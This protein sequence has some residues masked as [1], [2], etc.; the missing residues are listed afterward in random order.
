MLRKTFLLVV[1]A[2]GL[3]GVI[4]TGCAQAA[5]APLTNNNECLPADGVPRAPS[6]YADTFVRQEATFA[7][8][9]IAE[10]F[11]SVGSEGNTYTFTFECLHSGYGDRTGQMVLQ[12]ITPHTAVVTTLG[13][14]TIVSAVLDGKWDM[15]AQKLIA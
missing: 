10:S 1:L 11:K 15:L 12:A 8:D 5:A 4:V 7:Y 2:L 13:G 14:D 3:L 9:G 6:W